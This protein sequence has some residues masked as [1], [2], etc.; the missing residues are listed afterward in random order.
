MSRH[1]RLPIMAR[2]RWGV[3]LIRLP[4]TFAEY[5]AGGP[6]QAVRTNRRRATA[7]G[8]R[9]ATVPTRDYLDDIFEINASEPSRQ[10]RP[11]AEDYLDRDEV[12]RQAE[13][14]P[15]SHGI[16]DADGRLRAYAI[17]RDV[18][19]AIILST[20]L[21]HAAALDDGVMYL[22]VSEVIRTAI[23]G[24][25]ADSTPLWV[26]YDTYWGAKPG[27]AYFKRRAGFLP[28]TVD[29]VWVADP[30]PRGRDRRRAAAE[31]LRRPRS[32]PGARSGRSLTAC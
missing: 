11:M 28:Y 32:R 23:E 31:W 5:L 21:G 9:Y 6:K 19:D 20:I 2:K 4:A 7:A 25:R 22:L 18:G 8:Y 14:H 3:A 24:R 12:A 26:M 27:L 16:L 1:P 15:I 17:T 29:W 30:A 13:R 10:G